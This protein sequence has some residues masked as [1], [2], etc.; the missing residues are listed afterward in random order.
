[1]TGWEKLQSSLATMQDDLPS[2]QDVQRQLSA[3]MADIGES[4][5]SLV[6]RDRLA[7]PLVVEDRVVD[8]VSSRTGARGL[9]PL[10]EK[11]EED[12]DWVGNGLPDLGQKMTTAKAFTLGIIGES[13]FSEGHLIVSPP[14]MIG[15]VSLGGPNTFEAAG[16]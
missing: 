15:F 5:D 14:Q 2:V 6:N 7:S 13:L 4:L 9:S 1:M 11:D 16:T 12:E 8:S 10:L 3:T